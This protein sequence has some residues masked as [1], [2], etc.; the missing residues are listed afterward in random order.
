MANVRAYAY[1]TSSVP[2]F[3]NTATIDGLTFS[4]NRKTLFISNHAIG[5][6]I[7]NEV[8]YF[9]VTINHYTATT[10]HKYIPL[11]G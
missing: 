10:E 4:T 2:D 3:G 8:S 9:E 11:Y 1:F 5:R 6:Y 7:K